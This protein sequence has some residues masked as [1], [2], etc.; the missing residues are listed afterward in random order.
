MEQ[1]TLQHAMFASYGRQPPVPTNLGLL[2]GPNSVVEPP[3]FAN[4]I[5]GSSSTTPQDYA[6]SGLSS[7][8][9]PAVGSVTVGVPETGTIALPS[10]SS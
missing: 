4:H 8:G 9:S 2:L 10:S 6:G 3:W 7:G 5:G 1:L